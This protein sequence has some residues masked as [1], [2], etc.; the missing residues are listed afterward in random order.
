MSDVCALKA[1]ALG[2]LLAPAIGVGSAGSAH[3]P[4]IWIRPNPNVGSH[5]A[6][7]VTAPGASF[8]LPDAA[9]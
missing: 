5:P 8:S 7:P 6:A 9:I 3:K 1:G 4:A 2:R